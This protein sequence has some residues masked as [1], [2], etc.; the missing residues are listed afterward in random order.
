M[1]VKSISPQALCEKINAGTDIVLIDVRTPI[2]FREVHATVAHNIP[3]NTLKPETLAAKYGKETIYM[4]CRGGVRGSQACEQ[5]LIAGFE[6]VVNVEGG[7]AAWEAAGLPVVRGHGV[8]SLERQVRIAAGL[9]VLL[10]TLLGFFIHPYWLIVPAFVGAG[11]VFAGI[12]NTCGMGMLLAKMPWNCCAAQPTGTS[13]SC[14]TR[15]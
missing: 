7:T 11:L 6:N 2:E 5:M 14:S 15:K 4:I 8:I 13:A 3:L 1:S 9:F 12:T 10:G